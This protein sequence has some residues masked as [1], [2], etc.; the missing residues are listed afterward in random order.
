[1]TYNDLE[2]NEY[3]KISE[4]YINV[5]GRSFKLVCSDPHGYWKVFHARNNKPCIHLPGHYTSL[6]DAIKAV[7][8]L[9]EDKLPVIESRKTVLTPKLK[10]ESEED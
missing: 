4:R 3:D 2:E 10:K 1:M 9:P 8:T 6:N 5:K 7:N